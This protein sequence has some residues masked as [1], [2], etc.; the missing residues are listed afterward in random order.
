MPD[1]DLFLTVAPFSVIAY[2]PS[3]AQQWTAQFGESTAAGSD[4]ALSPNGR[5]LLISG[6]ERDIYARMAIF[7]YTTE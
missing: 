4:S 3:G 5:T 7:A 6:S 1:G 2:S